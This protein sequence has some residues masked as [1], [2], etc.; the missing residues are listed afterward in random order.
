LGGSSTSFLYV[1]P[2][3]FLYQNNTQSYL[4]EHPELPRDLHPLVLQG[5]HSGGVVRLYVFYEQL[6]L[7]DFTVGHT[8]LRA[9]LSAHLVHQFG[10]TCS[11]THVDSLRV[12]VV[13]IGVLLSIDGDHEKFHIVTFLLGVKKGHPPPQRMT[14]NTRI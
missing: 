14:L 3:T 5:T 2:L 8:T 7:Y 4:Q 6:R 11:G 10:Y 12:P 13:F 9:Y 1:Y